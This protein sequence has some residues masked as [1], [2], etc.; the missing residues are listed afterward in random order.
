MKIPFQTSVLMSAPQLK[1]LRNEVKGKD[2]G[3][4][5]EQSKHVTGLIV[6]LIR[7]CFKNRAREGI[8]PSESKCC[9]WQTEQWL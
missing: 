6:I 5:R 2:K 9:F 3:K 7:F 1:A 8:K 4:Q